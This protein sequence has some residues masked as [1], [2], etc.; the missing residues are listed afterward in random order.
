MTPLTDK[1][2]WDAPRNAF[3]PFT[4]HG[5]PFDDV[6]KRYIPRGEGR[7]VVEIGAYPGAFLLT[8]AREFELRPTAVDFSDHTQ[9]IAELFEHNGCSPPELLNCDFLELTGR[10]FDVVTSFGFVEHFQQPDAVIAKHADMVAPGGY[11][12]ISV[13]YLGGW[14]GLLRRLAYTDEELARIWSSHNTRIM[15]LDAL[16]SAVLGQGLELLFGDYV[17]KGRVWI[18]PDSHGVRNG[19][20][21]LVRL[22][23]FLDRSVFA[24]LPSS[25]FWSPMILIV[26]TRPA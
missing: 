22:A 13:P 11:L 19:A 2:Y 17:M 10:E 26:A 18:E 4:V 6:L 1:H 23:R 7:S 25:R 14:Q 20:R 8:L 16:R 3:R 24:R 5:T 9:D 15:N 21:W 12:V